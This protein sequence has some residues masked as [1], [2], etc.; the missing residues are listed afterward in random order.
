MVNIR[1]IRLPVWCHA[2]AL[3]HSASI[4]SSLI[5]YRFTTFF[6][7]LGSSER[8]AY[9]LYRL[10]ELSCFIRRRLSP[11]WWW[12]CISF[13]LTHSSGYGPIDLV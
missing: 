6:C 2:S 3:I 4:A 9:A 1:Q 8:T 10:R 7:G 12:K 5:T 11:K 13:P